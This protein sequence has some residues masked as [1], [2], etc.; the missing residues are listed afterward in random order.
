LLGLTPHSILLFYGYN[1]VAKGWLRVHTGAR[2]GAQPSGAALA[3]ALPPTA[4]TP[5]RKH[6]PR[7]NCAKPNEATRTNSYVSA[8]SNVT[9]REDPHPVSR[10]IE[11]AEEEAKHH[12]APDGDQDSQEKGKKPQPQKRRVPTKWMTS[13]RERGK[14]ASKCRHC[15][16]RSEA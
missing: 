4:V 6:Q 12:F 16:C 13:P 2:F 15:E 7:F 9:T 10:R 3:Y 14:R 1:G 5:G 11:A 8:S